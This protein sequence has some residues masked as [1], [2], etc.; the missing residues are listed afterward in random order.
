MFERIRR[1]VRSLAALL[2]R[3]LFIAL[4]A[5]LLALGP[6]LAGPGR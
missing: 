5:G 3:L 4:S 2:R 6:G 1:L